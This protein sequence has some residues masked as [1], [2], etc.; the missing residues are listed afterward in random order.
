MP[1]PDWM[2]LERAS[3]DYFDGGVK[4]KAM[5]AAIRRGELK[6]TRVTGRGTLFVCRCWLDE[7][8]RS[9]PVAPAASE[10]T[11]KE[12]RA[13]GRDSGPSMIAPVPA[14]ATSTTCRVARKLETAQRVPNP[15]R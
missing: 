14:S 9:R 13:A 1:R 5:R 11:Q 7:W 8:I 3:R 6:A 4:V 10:Q 12:S 15:T 2:P